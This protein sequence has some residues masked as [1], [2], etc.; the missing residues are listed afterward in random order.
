MSNNHSTPKARAGVYASVLFDACKSGESKE[1]VV[2]ARNQLLDVINLLSENVDARSVLSS[3]DADLDDKLKLASVLTQGASVEV[4]TI[5]NSIV[6]NGDIQIIK[7]IFNEL[8]SLISNDLKVCVVD[9]TT[10]VDLNDTLRSQIKDKAKNELGMDAILNEKVDTSILGGIIMSV[11][12][13]CIDAS[14][15]T[16]LNRARAVLKAS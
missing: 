12:G 10:S 7:L 4:K 1:G 13:K 5:V 3:S 9:V 15:I 11:N 16:Q 14:M 8:E 6:E 2:Q